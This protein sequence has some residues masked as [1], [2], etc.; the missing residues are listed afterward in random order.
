[1]VRKI[2]ITTIFNDIF[3]DYEDKL[4]YVIINIDTEKEPELIKR[5]VEKYGNK[6]KL[7]NDNE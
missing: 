4:G 5:L 1:M 6:C 7:M 3:T 2:K